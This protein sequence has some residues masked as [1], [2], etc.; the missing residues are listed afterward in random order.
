[1]GMVFVF[2]GQG[3]QY[4]GMAAGILENDPAAN[5]V[6]E[7]ASEIA[8]FDI[9][10]LCTSG[11]PSLLARTDYC[12]I[13]VAATSLA[14][15]EI[16]H[17]RSLEAETAAGHSLG[18]YCAACAAGCMDMEDT[19]RLVWIRGRAMLDCSRRTQGSMLALVGLELVDI[20]PLLDEIAGRYFIHLANHNSLTQ[21]VVSGEEAGLA[22]M[23]SAASR[24]GAR[25][26]PLKVTGSFHTP[27]M[28]DARDVVERYLAQI[29][30]KDPT[31]PLLSGFTGAEVSDAASVAHS[32]AAGITSP[33][34]WW[35]IQKGLVK[36]GADPQV[37]VGPGSTLCRMA[38]RD[39]PGLR[40][41]HAKDLVKEGEEEDPCS[42]E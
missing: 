8:G 42:S 30:I 20:L 23:S 18:E 24:L 16:L 12:Q 21:V 15:L 28:S 29:E 34:N 25:A 1:M 2:P 38:R 32:L 33:V 41:C 26:I 6:Y 22:A 9:H 27:A 37:E 13:G 40:T 31:V 4:P 14:W 19:L 5:M 36:R 11:D 7:M 39:Y 17:Q 3:S 10:K 35:D